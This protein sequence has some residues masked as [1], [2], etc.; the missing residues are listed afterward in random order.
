MAEPLQ[1][2][3]RHDRGKHH[4]RRLRKAGSIPAVLYG[5]RKENLC[6][7]VPAEPLDALVHHGNRLVTL[8]GAVNE[9]AFIREIQWDVWGTHVLHVDFTRI[10]EHET[11][12]VAVPVEVRGEAPGVR[13]GGI[14]EQLI[15]E[16]EIEC[17]ASAIPER[18]LVN[19]NHLR[20]RDSITVADL[21]LPEA[22][23]ALGDSATV[24]VHCIEPVEL[25]EVEVVE[26][27][28]GE[29]EVIGE[30]K[31]KPETEED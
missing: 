23:V 15:H 12:Q 27:A 18:L 31:E 21:Q 25:P 6:L 17:P 1:V 28:A 20:L 9:S 24:V 14:V 13:E 16:V 7:A 10:S 8:C 2:E 11:V 22:A 3:L 4:N 5:H 29:P 26:A 30:G 19:I